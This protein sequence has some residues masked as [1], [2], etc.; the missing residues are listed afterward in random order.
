MTDLHIAFLGLGAMGAGMAANLLR[1]GH[2]LVVYDA[3]PDAVVRDLA[4]Q[5][6]LAPRQVYNVIQGQNE[7]PASHQAAAAGGVAHD[8]SRLSH[9][10]RPSPRRQPQ[11]GIHQ[12]GASQSHG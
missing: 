11:S 12:R 3:S 8:L 4:V 1:A 10:L 5:A 6:G 2:P 7:E 9:T